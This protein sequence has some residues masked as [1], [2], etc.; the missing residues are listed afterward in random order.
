[1]KTKLPLRFYKDK[2]EDIYTLMKIAL[3]PDGGIISRRLLEN[4][5][6]SLERVTQELKTYL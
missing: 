5:I 3:A 2:F 1:M 6:S 4:V